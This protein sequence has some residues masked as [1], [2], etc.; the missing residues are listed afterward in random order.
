MQSVGEQVRVLKG[1]AETRTGRRSAADHPAMPRLARHSA[2]LLARYVVGNDKKTAYE[3]LKEKTFAGE[4]HPFGER[5]HF[6]VAVKNGEA[7]GKLDPGWRDGVWL[8][9]VRCD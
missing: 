9:G 7:V 5:V 2:E 8:G 3:R 4:V 1:A 6:K